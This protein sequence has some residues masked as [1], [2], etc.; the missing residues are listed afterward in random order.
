MKYIL[1]V[2]GGGTRGCYPTAALEELER[3]TGKLTRDIFS[4]VSGTSTGSLI[5][6]ACA[7][8]LPATK[9]M[10]IYQNRVKDI[11]TH[12]GLSMTYSFLRGYSDNPNNIRRVL[13][14]E[15]GD[16]SGWKLNDCNIKVMI[17]AVAMNGHT[18]FMCNDRPKNAG[19]TGNVLLIDAATASSAAPVYLDH[20]RLAIGDKDLRF[21]DGGAAGV[22]S[23]TYQAAVEAFEY[24]DYK[25]EDT[26]IIS[27]GTGFYPRED[28]P[29]DGLLQVIEWTL[30]TLLDS[31][32]DAVDKAVARQWPGI[33]TKL[34][35]EL[36]RPITM[37]DVDSVPDMILASRRE[38]AKIDW[39][40]LLGL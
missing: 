3:Q 40:K 1:C 14:D 24:D 38:A 22:S 5:C 2:A 20:F 33:S 21:Y 6:S 18:W 29:P 8:G 13:Q 15:F 30:D 12:G 36:E 31:A 32:D 16:K 25:P 39:I 35:W 11:F 26:H 34:N 4:F 10:G 17:P 9:I 23:T 19:T 37:A 7:V 27:L 28:T